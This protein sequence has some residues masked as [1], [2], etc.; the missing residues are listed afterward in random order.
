MRNKLYNYFQKSQKTFRREYFLFFLLPLIA[1]F[2]SI[3]ILYSY[4]IHDRCHKFL[5]EEIEPEIGRLLSLSRNE[6]DRL[7]WERYCDIQSKAIKVKAPGIRKKFFE[8]AIFV[9]PLVS[10]ALFFGLGCA[11][12]LLNWQF[13]LIISISALVF[14]DSISAVVV[15]RFNKK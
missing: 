5:A 11:K 12:N 6:E 1:L 4:T 14:F 8:V 2:Y 15:Y 3:Q 7:S 13:L 9:V 10:S